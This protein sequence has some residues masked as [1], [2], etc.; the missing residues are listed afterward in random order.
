MR[1]LQNRWAWCR[2][3][4][5]LS[6]VMVVRRQCDARQTSTVADAGE[7]FACDDVPNW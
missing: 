4:F 3:V 6:I 7:H 2:D 5:A 1:F